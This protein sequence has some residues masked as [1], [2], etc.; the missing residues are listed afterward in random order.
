M[1]CGLNPFLLVTIFYIFTKLGLTC[2]L[3]ERCGP[4]IRSEGPEFW[5]AP[6]PSSPPASVPATSPCHPGRRTPCRSA[7]VT[8]RG[9]S[10]QHVP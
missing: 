8:E 10:L 1:L 3:G 4:G 6:G 7:P 2:R 5:P 9:T